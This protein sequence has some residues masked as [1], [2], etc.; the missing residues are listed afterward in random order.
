MFQSACALLLCAHLAAAL[1]YHE[2]S[3][4]DLKDDKTT[5]AYGFSL[6]YE[7]NDA[8]LVIG[9]PLYNT[10]GKV[11]HCSVKDIKNKKCNDPVHID[12]KGISN[13]TANPDQ[14]F[15]LGASIAAKKNGFVVCAPLRT[16]YFGKIDLHTKTSTAFGAC[17]IYDNIERTPTIWSLNSNIS[18]SALWVEGG[19]GWSTLVD[20]TNDRVIISQ[21]FE[22]KAALCSRM[23]KAENYS[24]CFK[25][26]GLS[27]ATT[28][29]QAMSFGKYFAEKKICYAF[30]VNSIGMEK[31]YIDFFS[32]DPLHAFAPGLDCPRRLNDKTESVGSMFGAALC[33]VDVTSDGLA[34][35]IVGAPAQ[36]RWAADYDTGAT[37]IYSKSINPFDN[38][39]VEMDLVLTIWGV[40][41][42]SRF[43][44]TLSSNDV[45]GDS[46]P[47]II[48]SAPFEKSGG[49][50][51]IICGYAIHETIKNTRTDAI[52][53]LELA[54]TQRI[55]K[56]KSFGFSLQPVTDYND[57]GSDELAV[58]APEE[59]TVTMYRGIRAITVNVTSEFTDYATK[60]NTEFGFASC[61][62]IEKPKEPKEITIRLLV[63]NVLTGDKATFNSKEKD[64]Y[65]IVLTDKPTSINGSLHRYCRDYLITSCFSCKVNTTVSLI[66]HIET[67]KEFKNTWVTISPQSSLTKET[68]PQCNCG[69]VPCEPAY[70]VE[71]LWSG[72]TG[73][74]HQYIVGSSD[75]ETVTVMVSNNGTMGCGACTY[76]RVSGTLV[77]TLPC[78]KEMG[79]YKCELPAPFRTG[80]NKTIDIQLQTNTLSIEEK[81]LTIDVEVRKEC[82]KPDA[83][84]SSLTLNYDFENV[85][86][87]VVIHGSTIHRVISD[88][89]L[90]D[91]KEDKLSVE[92]T[93]TIYNNQSFQWK[94]VFLTIDG[95]D[96]TYIENT[97]VRVGQPNKCSVK[98]TNIWK[99]SIPLAPNST[100]TIIVSSTVIKNK[101]AIFL[102][103]GATKIT[104][105]LKLQLLPD[106][107]KD[108]TISTVI[109]LEEKPKSP[110]GTIMIAIGV[111]LLLLFIIGVILYK[112]NFFKRKT[113]EEL[114][115]LKNEMGRQS[116]RS[117]TS[118][119]NR[120]QPAVDPAVTVP[121]PD[122]DFDV[123]DLIVDETPLAKSLS[124]EQL[125]SLAANSDSV[126]LDGCPKK[127]DSYDN[128]GL[129]HVY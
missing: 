74:T 123:V 114:E 5:S 122:H 116:S 89:E 80:T 129:T 85:F 84:H 73:G 9:A 58:G 55:E 118:S 22:N 101:L 99:C 34:E 49:V 38:E 32:N 17:F 33:S 127:P 86:E 30:S 36:H 20:D 15:Y 64:T 1:F 102:K 4:V 111:S 27:L 11:Y 37:H 113:K 60:T 68:Q 25:P 13:R 14:H 103:K 16:A 95:M 108:K 110:I 100:T 91:S 7:S 53:V 31:G 76:V 28:Y 70:S 97:M 54:R 119:D 43:G 109:T 107:T 124:S 112:L 52:S 10:D 63:K 3:A 46:Y 42:G 18:I 115:V 98:L 94:K 125:N 92:Q 126:K 71:L 47:E 105:K 8:R 75:M 51:Y 29:G 93:Y 65:E 21:L 39:T 66:E 59:S 88:A 35:L 23:P 2:L 57:N 40:K 67:V 128:D 50:L 90:E 12:F 48:V 44:T 69:G 117:G 19:G 56:S 79:A 62:T 41:S 78:A 104:S 87:N 121:D 96:N 24:E 45:N 106:K 82:N 77:H 6:G 83:V 26:Q 120:T 61:V 81:G 72:K